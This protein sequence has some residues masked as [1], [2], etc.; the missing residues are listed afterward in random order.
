MD[1]IIIMTKNPLTMDYRIAEE[2][3]TAFVESGYN[4]RI[5]NIENKDFQLKIQEFID[6][7]EHPFFMFGI[8]GEGL[9]LE[10]NGKA[11]PDVFD[12]PY[13]A[14]L[15]DPPYN[16][17]TVKIGRSIKHLIVAYLDRS[18]L[19]FIQVVYPKGHIKIPLFMPYAGFAANDDALEKILAAKREIPVGVCASY[20]DYSER[21][22][23]GAD[24]VIR[25]L[26]DDVVEYFIHQPHV[27]LLAAFNHVARAYGVSGPIIERIFWRCIPSVYAFL[28]CYR[29][30]KC[31]ETALDAGLAVDI[32]GPNWERAKLPQTGV[33]LHGSVTFNQSIELYRHMK[34]LL[35]ENA[36]FDSGVHDRVLSGMMNGAALVSDTSLYI[37]EMFTPGK[38]I[39]LYEWDDLNNMPQMIFEL[40]TNEDRRIDMIKSS[41]AKVKK[42][43]TWKNRAE[44]IIRAVEFYQCSQRM[45]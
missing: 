41:F 25:N 17:V 29:R 1:T 39:M 9:D 33:H 4:V 3:Q 14:L 13:V 40:L 26:L 21:S 32:Y 38:D 35:S 10:I 37:R 44:S 7:G 42:H 23:N 6:S 20:Y 18:H 45:Q 34:V 27:A 5:I 24:R 31:I 2:L 28:R 19:D 8:N 16:N 22:W 11:L 43:H 36:L 30:K 15:S 12:I